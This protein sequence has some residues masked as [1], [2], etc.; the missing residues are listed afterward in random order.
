[1]FSMTNFKSIAGRFTGQTDILEAYLAGGLWVAAAD[2]SISKAEAEN[3]KSSAV[4]DPLVSKLF[5][6]SDVTKTFEELASKLRAA[7][8][9][10]K[11]CEKELR[12]VAGKGEDVSHA[13]Y[14]CLYKTANADN[15]VDADERSVLNR[16]AIALGIIDADRD[17]IES[18][19]GSTVT[20]EDW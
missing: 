17:A 11:A 12:D 19:V 16:A 5:S 7:P 2:G 6:A 10:A 14:L 4:N 1:M 9:F 3:V 20:F 8:D 18:S 13:V 15:N